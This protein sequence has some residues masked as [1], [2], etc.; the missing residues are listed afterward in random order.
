MGYGWT[1]VGDTYA[2]PPICYAAGTKILCVENGMEVYKFIETLKEGDFVKTYLHGN[3]PIELIK[4]KKIVNNPDKWSE[5]MYTRPSTD[6]EFEDLVVTGGHGILKKILSKEEI[7]ADFDWFI[8]NRRYSIIDKMYLQRAAFCNEFTKIPNKS[9][10]T[11][12]HLSLK[13]DTCK[14]YGIWANGVLSESTFKK[15][16]LR[17]F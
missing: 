17:M 11:Y 7:K 16:M 12:Y 13:G 2:E 5:C 9:E 8:K 4:S 1:I 15:D 6:P 10:Y 3:L 14:R